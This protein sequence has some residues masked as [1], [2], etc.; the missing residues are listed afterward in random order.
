MEHF[1]EKVAKS[2]IEKHP[3]DLK[4]ISVIVPSRRSA[5]FLYKHLARLIGKSFIAPRSITWREFLERHSGYTQLEHLDAVFLLYQCYL[6]LDEKAESFEV[7]NRWASIILSDFNEIDNYLLDA[8]SVF[9]NLKEFKDIDDWSFNRDDLSEMQEDF[10]SF[11]LLLKDLYLEFNQVLDE[12]KLAYAGKLKK[13]VLDKSEDL[14]KEQGFTYWIGFYA[15]PPAEQKI[16]DMFLEQS[17]GYV[18][19][20]ADD[21]YIDNANN[22]AGDFFR[23][24]IKAKNKRYNWIEN[25]I[26]KAK[27]VFI[28]ESPGHVFQCNIANDVVQNIPRN[29][30]ALILADED[31]LVPTLEN[32]DLEASNYNVSM[33]IPLHKSPFII[34][35]EALI[36]LH[37]SAFSYSS[38]HGEYKYLNK[39]ITSIINDPIICPENDKRDELDKVSYSFEEVQEILHVRGISSLLPAFLRIHSVPHDLFDRI[40]SLL[41]Y[42]QKEV[43]FDEEESFQ[44]EMLFKSNL[45]LKKLINYCRAYPFIESISS[46]KRIVQLICKEQ[47]LEFFG[48]PVKEL[49]V[50]SLLESRALDFENIIILGCNEGVLP[51]AQVKASF[52]PFVLKQELGLPS[53]KEYESIFAYYFYRL[54]HRCKSFHLIFNIKDSPLSAAEKSRFITQLEFEKKF[55]RFKP[56]IEYIQHNSNS[57]YR[58]SKN[59]TVAKTEEMLDVIK[60]KVL[61]NLSPSTLNK[62]LA[63]PLDFYF[64]KVANL[65]AANEIEEKLKANTMGSIAHGILHKLYKP[66]IGKDNFNKDDIKS[67]KGKIQDQYDNFVREENLENLMSSA[68]NQLAR[69]AVFQMIGKFLSNEEKLMDKHSLK[70]VSL[71]EEFKAR[72]DLGKYQIGLKGIIDRVD[73]LDDQLRIIDYKTGFVNALELKSGSAELSLDLL[74]EKGKITQLLFYYL[75]YTSKFPKENPTVGIYSTVNLSNYP[76]EVELNKEKITPVHMDSFRQTLVEI[77]DQMLDL[78]VAFEHREKNLYCDFCLDD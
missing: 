66:Y 55:D 21:Y 53:R 16:I 7:F 49:Q 1:L 48:E 54:L 31:L 23:K 71:E 34:L 25:N 70:I 57:H 28:H 68:Y 62:Y 59:A 43:S 51:N 39:H 33:Q 52:L 42:I 67:M 73:I 24:S 72:V 38:N 9:K 60:D 10:S 41:L 12:N 13:L 20:D 77:I 40:Q 47:E 2:L 18:Y 65:S 78:N 17:K 6:K 58:E 22:L 32:L 44:T 45:F 64:S 56:Q 27:N 5:L 35:T 14:V 74:R 36:S 50:I 26:N 46:L 15:I 63:C 19:W 30:S 69:E 75:L 29:N 37:E 4:D 61:T 8:E 11:W 76:F 3:N